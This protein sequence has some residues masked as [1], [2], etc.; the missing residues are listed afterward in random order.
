MTEPTADDDTERTNWRPI[1][2]DPTITWMLRTATVL[3]FI[4][5]LVALVTFVMLTLAFVLLLSGASSDASFVDWVYRNT[6]RAMDPFRGM[7]P[8]HRG[9][10]RSVFDASL[11]VAAAVYGFVALGLHAMVI[12]LT[13]IVRRSQRHT[14][15][16]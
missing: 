7:Y 4:V 5:Y 2:E 11:L 12:Y 8:T 15:T 3:V 13:D 14:N 9:D 1:A 16:R 6:E 10:G